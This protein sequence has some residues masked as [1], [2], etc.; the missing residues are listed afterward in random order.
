MK[1]ITTIQVFKWCT[2]VLCLVILTTDSFSNNFILPASVTTTNTCNCG[3]ELLNESFETFKRIDG[4]DVPTD[5]KYTGQFTKDGNYV[6][7]GSKIGLLTGAGSFS[8]ESKNVVPGSKVT[9]NIY[10]GYHYFANHYFKLIFLDANGGELLTISQKLDKSISENGNKLKKY[11]LL[12]T[13]PEGTI[14]I[15]VMG[16]ATGGH[17][18][19]DGACLKI[20]HPPVVCNDCEDNKLKNPSFEETQWIG[21]REVPKFWTGSTKFIKDAAYVVCGSK[22][23]LINY[24]AGYFYQDVKTSPGSKVTLKIWGGY[25]ERKSQKFELLF[26]PATG[27][28]PISSVSVDLD[29]SVYDLKGKLKRYTLEALSPPGTSYV[30]V[31]GSSNGDYFKVDAACLTIIESSLPVKL[32]GF[33][34]ANSEGSVKLLWS[35]ASELNA[36]SFE[37]EQSVT[38]ASWQTVGEVAARG[39]SSSVVTYDYL[40]QNPAAGTNLYRLKMIDSD[41]SFAYSSVVSVK[42]DGNAD[43]TL[44]PNPATDYITV[45]S[46][47]GAVA[48]VK[49]FN[50][51]GVLVKEVAAGGV[52]KIELGELKSGSYIV[53][54]SEISGVV[55]TRRIIV[56]K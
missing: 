48:Y 8:Q 6:V 2:I 37:I 13:A 47:I 1:K 32:I 56:K 44:Y 18:K 42:V 38:G 9:L 17:F 15:K 36:S 29:K 51:N 43:I 20:E 11:T 19:V 33:K 14:K 23:A 21:N 3:D 26:Y 30:Q 31:R 25:H 34:A 22:S 45:T 41:N 7:C 12:G 28:T 53:K 27:N 5:W 40:H 24:A 35:T 49:I 39:E 10:G 52:N 54:I 55:T 4:K 50:H 16:T 46:S